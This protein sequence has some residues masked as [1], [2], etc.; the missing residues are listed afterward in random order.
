MEI[1]NKPLLYQVYAIYFI[2]GL[3][4]CFEGVFLPEFKALFNLSYTGQMYIL[5]AKNIPFVFFSIGIGWLTRKIG[6]KNCL[7]VSLLL[8]ALG[9]FLI[10]PG[11]RSGNYSL[12]LIAFFILGIAFNMEL[13]AGNPLLS[14]LGEERGSSSRLNTGS[15]LGAIAQIIAPLL[16]VMVIPDSIPS[17][18]G[19]IPYMQ[20]IFII[21]ALVLLVMAF[22]TFRIKGS[23]GKE[24]EGSFDGEELNKSK[25]GQPSI[26]V[27][28]KIILGFI[29]LFLVLGF[30]ACLFGFYRNFAEDKNLAGLSAHQSQKMFTV[31]FA[32]F[33]LGRLAGSLL[34]KKIKPVITLVFGLVI[35]LFLLVPVILADGWLA[36][37]AYT[38]IG[39]FV[40]IF[41]PTLFSI[42]IEG[43]S[44]NTGIASGLL[45]MGFLGGALLPVLQGKLADITS[46]QFSFLLGFLPY[47]FALFYIWKWNGRDIYGSHS[48]AA[49]P[50]TKK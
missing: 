11:L 40:S 44:G 1:R 20:N 45:T 14:V 9:T 32:V 24:K 49:I 35:V 22:Y 46:L 41:F 36:L 6:F 26:W 25:S 15:A 30:E 23:Q 7:A 4:Q 21:T 47:I 39:F 33:A 3:A 43:L 31:Y 27:Q 18:A 38:A 10:V 29:S 34:Q 28:P 42:S 13:V 50:Q 16:L 19:K 8:F 17:I 37:A 48:T 12:L 2:C 5:F